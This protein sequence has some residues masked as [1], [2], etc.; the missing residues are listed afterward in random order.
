MISYST[1]LV[2]IAYLYVYVGEAGPGQIHGTS[3]ELPGRL[4][5][6][7]DFH[8]YLFG[9]FHAADGAH[10]PLDGRRISESVHRTFLHRPTRR[11]D[12]FLSWLV[13]SAG[14]EDTVLRVR[15]HVLCCCFFSYFI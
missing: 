7:C 5:V 15:F 10:G 1:I 4:H 14:P 8:G 12:G 9:D 3:L 11:S 13:A 2:Y 6:Q